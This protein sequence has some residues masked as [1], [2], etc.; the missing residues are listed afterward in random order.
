M[1]LPGRFLKLSVGE[2]PSLL[3]DTE[4]YHEFQV[5]KDFEGD[6]HS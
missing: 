1:C 4:D 2:V 3:N 5:C 6:Y